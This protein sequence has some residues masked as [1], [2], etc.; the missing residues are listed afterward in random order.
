MGL[1]VLVTSPSV[2]GSRHMSLHSREISSSPSIVARLRWAENVLVMGEGEHL[3]A[4]D[5]STL[6]VYH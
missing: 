2:S 5:A 1:V 4:V 3:G 6:W